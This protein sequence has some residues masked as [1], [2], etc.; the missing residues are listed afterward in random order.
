MTKADGT[1]EEKVLTP[2]QLQAALAAALEKAKQAEEALLK[3]QEEKAAAEKEARTHQRRADRLESKLPGLQMGKAK[4]AV[5]ADGKPDPVAGMKA[6]EDATSEAIR[7]NYLLRELMARGLK[8][9]DLDELDI[10]LDEIQTQTELKLALDGLQMKRQLQD[11][12][13]QV[14]ENK[15]AAEAAK[16]AGGKPNG[17]QLLID[18][19]EAP[20]EGWTRTKDVTQVVKD[21]RKRS[22]EMGRTTEARQMRLAAIYLDDSKILGSPVAEE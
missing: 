7:Q 5:G 17:S 22:S 1:E 13:K 16:N 11:V 8:E 10:E 18:T 3:T 20:P 6:L 21:L 9:T 12:G 15:A 19:G 2:E 4:D 14:A